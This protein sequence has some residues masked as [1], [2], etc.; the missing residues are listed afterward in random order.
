MTDNLPEKIHGLLVERLAKKYEI[1][2]PAFLGG[3][4][5]TVFHPGKGRDGKPLAPFSDA[6]IMAALILADQYDLNPFARQLYI[7]RAKGRLLVIVPI[8]GWATIVNRHEMFDGLKCED[9]EDEERGTYIECTMWHKAR[10]Q[11][12]TIREYLKECKRD[13]RDRNGNLVKDA[14]WNQFPM[15]MLRHKAIIQCARIAFGLSG[16]TDQDEAEGMGARIPEY[17]VVESNTELPKPARK[18]PKEVTP[19]KRPAKRRKQKIAKGPPPETPEVAEEGEAVQATLDEEAARDENLGAPEEPV[20]TVIASGPG[21]TP[22]QLVNEIAL[23]GA[24]FTEPE[25]REVNEAAGVE[26]ITIDCNLAQLEAA[27]RKAEEISGGKRE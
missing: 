10:A 18:A 7:T 6:E 26:V 5:D 8:D 12:T 19:G 25:W 27:V 1:P 21:K 22:A 23:I 11:P 17:Q 24:E 3:L 14:P 20:E 4:R 13:I 9:G 16:L 15:R 2:A